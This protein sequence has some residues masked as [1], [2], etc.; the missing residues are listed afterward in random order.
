METRAGD[1]GAFAR[2]RL[3]TSEQRADVAW[4]LPNSAIVRR[5]ALRGA[6][7]I[8]NDRA[9]LRWLQLGREES[10]G[11]EVLAGLAANERVAR[12]AAG[13]EDGARVRVR[14]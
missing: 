9:E 2:V 11:A 12:T 3:I 7:V 5:G 1:P 10:G 6:F 13:L 8:V 14:P 4:R